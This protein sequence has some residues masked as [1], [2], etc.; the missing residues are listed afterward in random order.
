MRVESEG[1]A[2][3][4]NA[5][6]TITGIAICGSHPA[7]LKFAP[8]KDE[9]WLIYACSPD[10]TPYGLGNNAQ[11]IPRFDEWF[12]VHVPIADKSR[13]YPYLRYLESVPKVWM[14]DKQA[15]GKFPGAIEYPEAEM[16]AKFCPF[17]FTS[18]IGFIMAKAITDCEQRGIKKL[19]LF[20]ILQASQ[21]EYAY[22][23][24]GTQYFMWEA[25]RRGIDVM[26]PDISKLGE[27]PPEVF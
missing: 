2:G 7:T 5:A 6:S 26:V 8:F 21:Q 24:S 10:N 17:L 22:Q 1:I 25:A 9:S 15:M 19:G 16:K 27:P 12:E 23:R 20:G 3:G 18:S 13:P 4:G 14:R 11:A